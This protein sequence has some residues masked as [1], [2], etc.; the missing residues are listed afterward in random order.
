MNSHIKPIHN[1]ITSWAERHFVIGGIAWH[2]QEDL[3]QRLEKHIG[4]LLER[5][6]ELEVFAARAHGLIKQ[7]RSEASDIRE[8]LGEDEINSAW[9]EEVC[10]LDNNARAILN[11]KP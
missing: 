11:K 2:K 9:W 5:V 8:Q 1:E 6:K 4:P 3:E 7:C 10:Q